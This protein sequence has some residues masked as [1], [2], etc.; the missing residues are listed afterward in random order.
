MRGGYAGAGKAGFDKA[1][2]RGRAREQRAAPGIEPEVVM[3]AIG[4]EETRAGIGA[5]GEFHAQGRAVERV[6]A[7]QLRDTEVEVTPDGAV[8]RSR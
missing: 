6:A 3:I 2:G 7:L 5:L 4:S 8:E 1:E